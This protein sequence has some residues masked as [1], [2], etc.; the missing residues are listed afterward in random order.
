M[1]T[2]REA[3]GKVCWQLPTVHTPVVAQ[4]TQ[5]TFRASHAE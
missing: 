3:P 5:A 2:G 4:A 1:T